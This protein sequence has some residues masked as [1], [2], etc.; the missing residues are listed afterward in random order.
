MAERVSFEFE[1][2]NESAS[3]QA[4]KE[5]IAAVAAAQVKD[6]ESVMLDSGTTTLALAKPLRETR[7]D[8]YY[9]LAA[10]RCPIAV[11]AAD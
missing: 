4:A 8:C 2:L 9:H 3:N 5:A 10:H 7:V 11:R 6:G 1:F